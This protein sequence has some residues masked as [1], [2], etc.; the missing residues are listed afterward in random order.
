MDRKCPNSRIS[1]HAFIALLSQRKL[2]QT[3]SPSSY[4]FA[5]N[6]SN[7]RAY[8][9]FISRQMWDLQRQ[10]IVLLSSSILV[11][12]Y[13]D[14]LV[15]NEF[16]Q[17][18]HYEEIE[19]P[20]ILSMCPLCCYSVRCGPQMQI[21]ESMS[22]LAFLSLKTLDWASLLCCF[23]NQGNSCSTNA[24]LVTLSHCKL[25]MTAALVSPVP[26]R[27]VFAAAT[28]LSR[29]LNSLIRCLQL[30]CRRYMQEDVREFCTS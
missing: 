18:A 13:C 4:I 14:Q 19:H 17:S 24:V 5:T 23:Y 20:I 12:E 22:K 6:I 3:K 1:S 27:Q 21:A 15:V 25:L 26:L 7:F 30:K 10:S 2:L 29:S 28:V 8:L 9:S 11:C 16:K